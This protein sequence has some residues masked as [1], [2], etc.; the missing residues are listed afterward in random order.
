MMNKINFDPSKYSTRPET[1]RVE[2]IFHKTPAEIWPALINHRD[3][4][5]WM[6]GITS[7]EITH[8]EQGEEGLGCQRVCQFGPETL[9]EEIVF[10]EENIGYG[11]KISDNNLIEDHVAYVVIESLGKRRSRVS[12]RQHLKPKGNFIKQLLM[13]HIMFPLTLKKGLENLEKRIAA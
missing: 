6:P 12:W 8:N 9:Y 3:M 10:W 11:Y 7:V 1:I 2:R 5:D 4:V 13:K